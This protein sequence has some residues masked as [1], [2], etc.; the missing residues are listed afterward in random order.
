MSGVIR[1][2]QADSSYFFNKDRDFSAYNHVKKP[3]FRM[4]AL[5]L[6]A[7]IVDGTVKAQPGEGFIYDSFEEGDPQGMHDME[8]S[9]YMMVSHQQLSA[10]SRL[11][12]ADQYPHPYLMGRVREREV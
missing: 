6:L 7:D 3:W 4:P 9:G 1:Y 5:G 10:I 8:V 2:H 11:I 12:V